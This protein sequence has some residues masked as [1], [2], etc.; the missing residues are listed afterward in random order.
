M[1]CTNIITPRLCIITNIS[2]DHTQFLGNTLEEIATEKA[3]II[4]CGIP[5]VIGETTESTEKVFRTKANEVGAPIIFTE[6]EEPLIGAT[7]KGSGFEYSTKNYGIINGELGGN[8]QEKNAA[9]ILT[10]IEKAKT[11]MKAN[12]NFDLLME[13]LLLTI[14]EN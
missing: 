1:D 12:V 13:L 11:R 9:T 8:C 7:P 5:V 4:K 2:P 6:D 3:G 14:K 10:A